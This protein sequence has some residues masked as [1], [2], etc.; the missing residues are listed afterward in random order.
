VQTKL[1]NLIIEGSK[2]ILGRP[3]VKKELITSIHLKKIVEKFG[4]D[5]KNLY[6]L[7]I[8]AMCLVGYAGFLR[9]NEIANLKMCNLNIFYTYISLNI[10]SSK[11][12]IYRRGNNVI[13]SKTNSSTC[14]VSWFLRYIELADLKLNSGSVHFSFC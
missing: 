14:P 4:S 5:V 10:E 11:T 6:N 2:R 1:I 3:I 13:I 12:D 7:R 9:Y 8:C